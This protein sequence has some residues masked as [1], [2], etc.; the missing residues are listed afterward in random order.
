MT[1]TAERL[2]LIQS[3]T[4]KTATVEIIDKTDAAG[5]PVGTLVKIKLPLTD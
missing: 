4:D 2:K 3:G 5:K 1:V